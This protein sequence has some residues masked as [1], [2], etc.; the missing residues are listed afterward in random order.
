MTTTSTLKSSP[1]AAPTAIL[2]VTAPSDPAPALV[3]A[4][5]TAPAA[6][7]SASKAPTP[8]PSLPARSLRRSTLASA[9]YHKK[10]SGGANP[11]TGATT[12]AGNGF[13]IPVA[14]KK[15]RNGSKKL[16]SNLRA[17]TST[18]TGKSTNPNGNGSRLKIQ[19][20]TTLASPDSD[21]TSTSN[22]KMDA[23][24]LMAI[25]DPP[26]PDE[27]SHAKT[28]AA[29]LALRKRRT[30]RRLSGSM[31]TGIGT[32]TSKRVFSIANVPV[33]TSTDTD[34]ST[35]HTRIS[36]VAHSAQIVQNNPIENDGKERGAGARSRLN[37][38]D[39]GKY[40]DSA[41]GVGAE[42]TSASPGRARTVTMES[43]LKDVGDVISI[44]NL[45]LANGGNCEKQVDGNDDKNSRFQQ[46]YADHQQ[47]KSSEMDDSN[48]D[49]AEG[50]SMDLGDELEGE[51]DVHH[52]QPNH[53]IND[54][55]SNEEVVTGTPQSNTHT[56]NTVQSWEHK[57]SQ[58]ICFD[59]S[60]DE[61]ND[62]DEVYLSPLKQKQMNV[63]TEHQQQNGHNK[64]C[65]TDSPSSKSGFRKKR[66]RERQSMLIP[67]QDDLHNACMGVDTANCEARA[68]SEHQAFSRSNKS[69]AFDDRDTEDL[70]SPLKK[71]RQ[72]RNR[73]GRQSMILPSESGIDLTRDEDCETK[74]VPNATRVRS[75]QASSQKVT[76]ENCDKMMNVKA[77]IRKY[78]SLSLEERYKS[79]EA[80]LVEQLTGYP[81]ISSMDKINRKEM[82]K[83]SISSPIRLNW[84]SSHSSKMSPS[85]LV[86]LSN[87]MKRNLFEKIK[88][89]VQ[90]M[91]KK[92]KE[93]IAM[94]EDATRCRVERKKGKFRY[95][96]LTT[97][98]KV[99]ARE[100]ERRY[101][102]KI[103]EQRDARAIKDNVEIT[104]GVNT[105]P[106]ITSDE[107]EKTHAAY[108]TEKKN[109]EINNEICDDCLP[110]CDENKFDIPTKEEIRSDPELAEAERKMH[111]A[112]NKAAEE[113]SRTVQ[114]I[115]A[116]R[117][118]LRQKLSK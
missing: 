112:F 41:S 63:N 105:T 92:K 36:T 81:L 45:P 54:H 3:P 20:S 65:L 11:K 66:S 118:H 82:E 10:V 5:V 1:I 113:Y 71:M 103:K 108:R 51:K 109:V 116:Q 38:Y 68:D 115:R 56:E 17:G 73:S 88:P 85:S 52:H 24:E 43:H 86:K 13:P 22:D 94:L 117:K 69:L 34:T 8:I 79:D 114:R 84:A 64:I 98:K 102:Y 46:S 2:D 107:E 75:N 58:T 87:E 55:E 42:M 111:E 78:C 77:A 67:D 91:E 97:G 106:A 4:P 23:R 25:P 35:S 37:E 90:I 32:G 80:V 28:A 100:Y 76:L 9:G 50:D 61:D 21:G 6:S 48:M 18:G 15:V 30:S 104:C 14:S 26:T 110:D 27:R 16:N 7:V 62:G 72:E 39:N 49:W 57:P 29:A 101:L 47:E 89:L 83:G 59:G 96:S 70:A 53:I 33:S 12:I 93:D 99:A 60:D 40:K 95:V 31:S 19:N 74:R 44:N